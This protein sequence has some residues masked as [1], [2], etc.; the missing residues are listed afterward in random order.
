MIIV[1]VELRKSNCRN[2]RNVATV[3]TAIVKSHNRLKGTKI[4][5]CGFSGR[6]LKIFSKFAGKSS[7]WGPFIVK[8]QHVMS[9][10]RLLGQLYQKRDA[11]T[12]TLTQLLSVNFEKN[13]NTT[14]NTS[15]RLPL[16]QCQ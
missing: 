14:I 1:F 4:F 12:D 7:C 16:K 11:Y 2:G 15:A 5:A 10:N 3:L 13:K 6:N 8:L 9:Y